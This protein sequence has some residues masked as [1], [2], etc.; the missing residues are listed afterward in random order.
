MPRRMLLLGLLLAG[1][2]LPVWAAESAADRGRKAL[3]EKSYNPAGWTPEGYQNVWKRWPGV[4]EKP[5][6]YDKA[7]RDYYGLHAAP[8]PNAG[9]PMGLR[10]GWR[11][12]A[13]GIGVDCMI[14][15]G[16]SMLG[17][18]YVGLGNSSLDIEALF[19][20]L[21]DASGLPPRTPIRFCN[22]RGTSE[23]GGIGVY[24][25]G[26]RN[27]DLSLRPKRLE[28]GLQDDLCEDVPAWWHL[29]K[30]K[31]MYHTGGA[32]ARS[33]RSIMQFMMSPLN[34]PGVFEREEATFRDVR[35][36]LLTLEPPGVSPMSP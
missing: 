7:V 17:Q 27:P 20:D 21:N 11:L 33:V 8:Y 25:L 12:L 15:H 36:H 3:L 26:Y 34:G 28:L 4:T 29:K 23:A 13:K 35:E 22:V 5:A 31:T 24:L 18:S 19:V 16:G 10:E 1:L 6:N 9:L 2:A 14:C 30:K 32:D